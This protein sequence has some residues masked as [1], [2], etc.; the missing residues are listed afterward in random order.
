MYV[1]HIALS[2][3]TIKM[4]FFWKYHEPH[5]KCVLKK[6]I[7]RDRNQGIGNKSSE[8]IAAPIKAQAPWSSHHLAGT[9]S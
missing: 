7:T 2:T 1:N 4:D 8:A 9:R 3:T 5:A 6:K